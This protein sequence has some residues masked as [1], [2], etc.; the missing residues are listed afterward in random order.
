M[1]SKNIL[2]HIDSVAVIDIILIL[3]VEHGGLISTTRI[4]DIQIQHKIKIV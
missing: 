2:G 1:D 3:N 4:S